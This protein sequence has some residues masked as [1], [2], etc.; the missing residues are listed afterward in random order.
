[1]DY[2]LLGELEFKFHHHS[3]PTGL[4]KKNELLNEN[5]ILARKA[6]RFLTYNL[7]MRPPPVKT[8]ASDHKDARLDDF[9][10]QLDDFD[11]INI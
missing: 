5:S 9:V 1:M 11:I 10:K 7:F 4:I 3:I 2:K 6:I 8:N